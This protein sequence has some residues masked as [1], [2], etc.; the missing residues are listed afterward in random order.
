MH[1]E[2]SE[3]LYKCFKK[4][5]ERYA[6]AS[7]VPPSVDALGGGT[8]SVF[9]LWDGVGQVAWTEHAVVIAMIVPPRSTLRGMVSSLQVTE[10]R[11]WSIRWKLTKPSKLID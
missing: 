5:C 1:Q 9:W 8:R 2:R 4:Q 7:G 3:T 11:N 10:R 6:F